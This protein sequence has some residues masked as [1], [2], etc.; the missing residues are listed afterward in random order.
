M[1]V[2]GDQTAGGG[3]ASR[4]RIEILPSPGDSGTTVS[5]MVSAL[6]EPSPAPRP[7][8]P[9]AEAPRETLLDYVRAKA[10]RYDSLRPR[11]L[12]AFGKPAVV[13]RRDW[14]EESALAWA[15]DRVSRLRES[16]VPRDREELARILEL[17]RPYEG[18]RP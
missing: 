5:Q 1:G 17:L 16:N 3:A 11:A 8:A 7:S 2:P 9:E 14:D 15:K 12:N 18:S 10:G 4:Y 6:D 13:G